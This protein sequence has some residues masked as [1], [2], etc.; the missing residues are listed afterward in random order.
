MSSYIPFNRD[1]ALLLPPDLKAWLSEDDL[2][3]FVV[4]AVEWGA[5]DAFAV[6]TRTGGKLQY[7]LR[8]EA[9]NGWLSIA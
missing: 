6:T 1:Q 9:E 8:Q 4:A 7:H 5:L 2:V 3:H